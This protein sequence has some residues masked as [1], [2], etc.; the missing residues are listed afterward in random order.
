LT[1]DS[2]PAGTAVQIFAD[3][4]ES[5]T[6][7]PNGQSNPCTS[8]AVAFAG[9]DWHTAISQFSGNLLVQDDTCNS[10]DINNPSGFI[11]GIIGEELTVSWF[12]NAGVSAGFLQTRTAD[13]S[14][15][16]LLTP[17]GDFSYV[18]ASGNVYANIT[19]AEVPEPT[20]MLL[21]G[22]GLAFVARRARRCGEKI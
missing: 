8:A 5:W 1:S 7:T 12:L 3:L 15:R 13:A 18:A 19:A 10:F 11:Q 9:L 6:V 16:L 17:Q 22:S 4:D 14:L 21:L 20:T 2:L